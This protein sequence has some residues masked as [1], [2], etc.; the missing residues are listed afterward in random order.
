VA[1]VEKLF[2]LKVCKYPANLEALTYLTAD[3]N[4]L[5]DN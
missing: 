4:S 3:N 5:T 1:R 2:R